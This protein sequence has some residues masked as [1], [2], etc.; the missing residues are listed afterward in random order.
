M[1]TINGKYA[2]GKV[3]ELDLSQ[4]VDTQ[5]IDLGA[6]VGES[7]IDTIIERSPLAQDDRVIDA[8][9]RKVHGDVALA[10]QITTS[11]FL[12]EHPNSVDALIVVA[13]AC[14]GDLFKKIDHDLTTEASTELLLALIQ[15]VDP[16]PRLQNMIAR[17]K[18][19][20]ADRLRDVAS[21]LGTPTDSRLAIA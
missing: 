16:P 9:I 20:L 8:A 5:E 3:Y 7:D 13:D 10:L 15:E 17:I 21:S 6:G 4:E 19:M 11:R 14:T 12:A 2:D 18:K 1:A